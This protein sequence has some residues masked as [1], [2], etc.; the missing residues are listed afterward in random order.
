M[1]KFIS[2]AKAW[3]AES[4]SESMNILQV[5]PYYPPAWSYGG[6]ARV[7]FDLTNQLAKQGHQVCVLTTD[8]GGSEGRTQSELPTQ[9]SVTIHRF[10]NVTNI[11]AWK[12]RLFVAP[13]A[14]GQIVKEI[15]QF[16]VIHLHDYRTTLNIGI[17]QMAQQH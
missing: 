16:D 12:Y 9:M 17:C 1:D 8:A 10:R 5:V 14:M 11:A 2:R 6:P 7:A 4:S 3:P 15:D 13:G